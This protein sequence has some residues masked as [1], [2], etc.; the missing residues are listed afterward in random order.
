[1]HILQ[2]VHGYPPRY[3][4]GSEVYTQTLSR[5]LARR[6]QVMVFSRFEDPFLPPY[7]EKNETD[8]VDPDISP[9]PLRLINTAHFRDRYRH[10]AVD[11]AFANCLEDFA[12]DIVHIQHLNHLS[13]SLVQEAHRREIP[14]VFTLH[15]F[16]LMCPRGQFLQF[17]SENGSNTFS[18]CDGQEDRKCAE[19]CWSRYFSGAPDGQS[20]EIRYHTEW[21]R[22][23]MRHVREMT[24][25]VD[26][27]ISP[28]KQ[29]RQKFLEEFGLPPER[30]VCLD[31]GFNVERLRNRRRTP[32]RDREFV[33]G[34]IGTHV[35]AKGIHHLLDAFGRMSGNARL[36]I[37]GRPHPESTPAL[38]EIH[39]R[40]PAQVRERVS[41]EGEYQNHEIVPRVF[42]LVDAI[43]VPSIWLENSPLVI[44][45]AQQVRVPVITA[46]VGGMAELV[47]HEVNG[48]LFKHRNPA[49]LAVQM[50]RLANNPQWA[51]RLGRRGYL[52]DPNGDV[53]RTDQHAAEIERLYSQLRST[54]NETK[55]EVPV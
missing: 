5:S 12:P 54:R 11:R 19:R 43:V 9:I 8:A 25:L 21:V 35:P 32:E 13:T 20:E 30:V 51:I 55:R 4:A 40:L 47:Q 41:W 53:I 2:V 34:Y 3:N 52:N 15:D 48:L 44:H 42:N 36:R 28:S 6:H 46:D 14:I 16:W 23:R 45:E 50:S 29:L 33:F 38:K 27:F 49:S 7:A 37:W 18:L 22:C 31:Y 39:N 26:L 17:F 1:M 10:P 24:E